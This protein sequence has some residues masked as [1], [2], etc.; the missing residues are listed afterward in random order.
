MVACYSADV[1]K[2]ACDIPHT[3]SSKP[4]PVQ[5]DTIKRPRTVTTG[6][7]G[8]QQVFDGCNV[9]GLTLHLDAAH[10]LEAGTGRRPVPRDWKILLSG[11]AEI[12]GPNHCGLHSAGRAAELASRTPAAPARPGQ[13]WPGAGLADCGASAILISSGKAK[14][15][16]DF[17]S[18]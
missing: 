4:S 1:F 7:A 12:T 13:K 10:A 9:V 5:A 6:P 14:H 11:R 16:V 8:R 2:R 18:A 17:V 3:T 15:F